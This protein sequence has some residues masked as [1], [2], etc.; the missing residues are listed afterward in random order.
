M[1]TLIAVAVMV[2]SY[3]HPPRLSSRCIACATRSSRLCPSPAYP[4]WPAFGFVKTGGLVAPA[5]GP[6]SSSPDP[7]QHP[8]S[9]MTAPAS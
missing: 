2:A 9:P 4:D 3:P 6:A 5:L 8:H 1:I 7:P